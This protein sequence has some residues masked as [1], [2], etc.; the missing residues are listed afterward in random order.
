M[1][2]KEEIKK[3]VVIDG[4]EYLTFPQALEYIEI[5]R[6]KLK[7]RIL[8]KS[9]KGVVR[10]GKYLFVP[11]SYLQE[12]KKKE[13]DREAE[14]MLDELKG[15]GLTKEDVEKFIAIKKAEE[16]GKKK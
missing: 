14:T 5:N 8:R 9:V 10:I 16:A 12:E 3:V 2:E 4:V 11:L 1:T 7:Q 15:M 6:E 13:M